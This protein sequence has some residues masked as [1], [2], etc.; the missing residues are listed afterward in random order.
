MVL[1]QCP[2]CHRPFEAEL[3][4]KEQ[5]DSSEVANVGDFPLET[6]FAGGLTEGGLVV[7]RGSLVLGLSDDEKEA[8]AM[9]PEAFMTYKALYKCKHCGKEWTKISVEEKP[10]PRAYVEAEEEKTDYDA[11]IEAERAREEEYARE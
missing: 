2:F 4:S 8:V 10:I 11:H 6:R 3:L 1:H 5:V 7:S 9:H